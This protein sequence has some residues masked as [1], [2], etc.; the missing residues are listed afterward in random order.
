M[1]TKGYIRPE[2]KEYTQLTKGVKGFADNNFKTI[3]ALISS[4]ITV[5]TIFIMVEKN[6]ATFIFFTKRMRPFWRSHPDRL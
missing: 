2:V 1:F 3:L 6:P 4:S 5:K